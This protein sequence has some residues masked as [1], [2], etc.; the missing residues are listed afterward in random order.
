MLL[1]CRPINPVSYFTWT[2]SRH[3]KPHLF[4][5]E[6][7]ISTRVPHLSVFSISEKGSF[8]FPVAG[9]ENLGVI[10]NSSFS[11]IIH[12]NALANLV[13]FV[14][15]I[16]PEFATPH[17]LLTEFTVPSHRRLLLKY[18]NTSYLLS[19][20]PFSLLVC[21]QHSQQSNQGYPFKVISCP[22]SAQNLQ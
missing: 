6:I 2:Y 12:P 11:V 13:Y 5:F 4:Y 16:C 21:S 22:Y 17:H 9:E 10:L 1:T 3:L 7:L 14:F 15:K 20:P 19:L 8:I 18:C